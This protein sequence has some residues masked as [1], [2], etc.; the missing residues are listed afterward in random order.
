MQSQPAVS[1][2]RRHFGSGMTCARLAAGECLK[3]SPRSV[4]V[5][6]QS[7]PTGGFRPFAEVRVLITARNEFN[8][9]RLRILNHIQ[10][11]LNY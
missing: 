11:S 10:E 9:V 1:M 4:I 2:A 3:A 6:C 5:C 7:R 8:T